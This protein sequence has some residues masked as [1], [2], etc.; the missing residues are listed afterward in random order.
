VTDEVT[1]EK[2]KASQETSLSMLTN[3]TNWMQRKKC[4]TGANPTPSIYN[5]CAVNIYNATRSLVRFESNIFYAFKNALAYYNAGVV[6][7]NLK[8]VGLAPGMNAV[9]HH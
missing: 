5:A 6:V 4:K 1:T 9:K 3:F 7:V 2:K 8:I